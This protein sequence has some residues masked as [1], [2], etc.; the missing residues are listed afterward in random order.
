MTSIPGMEVVVPGSAEEF[1]NLLDAAYAS[2]QPTYYRLSEADNSISP[3][4]GFGQA[5]V[6]K[7]GTEAVV[8]AVG[9]MLSAVMQAAEGLDVTVLYYTTVAPFDAATLRTHASRKVLLCEPY[10]RGGLVAEITE[11]LWPEPVLVRS[12]G[13][14]RQF[15]TKYGHKADH[16]EALGLTPEAIRKDLELLIDA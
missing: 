5:A 10:Y 1:D 2:P 6:L 3:N 14:P 7:E 9:P 16:D 12:V 8:V 4:A 15:L 13:V 11:A